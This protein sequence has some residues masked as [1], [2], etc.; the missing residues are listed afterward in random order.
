MRPSPHYGPCPE[1]LFDLRC[2]L[3][4]WRARRAAG[5]ELPPLWPPAAREAL[6]RDLDAKRRPARLFA[7][8][9]RARRDMARV[10]ALQRRNS[11]SFNHARRR[12][13]VHSSPG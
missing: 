7:R 13:V 6:E 1:C 3:A 8:L 4:A 9:A 2:C 5:L 10:E 12:W 11:V